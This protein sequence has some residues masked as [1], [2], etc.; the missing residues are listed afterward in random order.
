MGIIG[1]KSLAAGRIFKTDISVQDAI[2]YSLSLPISTLVSGIDSIEVL[3]QN[4]KIAREFNKM[5]KKEL[6]ELRK[7]FKNEAFKGQHEYYKTD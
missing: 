4:L 1:M 7:R 6:N 5:S 2:R 3:E